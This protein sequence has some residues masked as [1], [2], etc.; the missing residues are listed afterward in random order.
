M[1][2]NLLERFLGSEHFNKDPSLTVAYLAR[3]ADHVGIQYVLC[4]KL[5]RFSYEEIE[6]FLPQLCHLLISLDNESMALE[7][8]MIDLCE[9]SVNAALLAFW[10][11][12]TYLRDLSGTPNSNAFKKCR[13]IYNRVQRIVFG[14]S[15]PVRREKIKDNVLPVTVLSSLV[16]ASVAAPFLPS[17]AGPLAI[18]QGRKPRPVE[19]MIS[20]NVQTQR[21]TRS[22]TVSGGQQRQRRARNV[23]HDPEAST[24]TAR[25]QI[26]RPNLSRRH[27]H[28]TKVQT[29]S[30]LSPRQKIRLLRSNYFKLETQFLTA[31]E[32]VS[33]RLVAVPKPARL[34]ALRAELALIAQDL[35]AEVDVPLICPATLDDGTPSKSRH[36]RI[37]RLNPAEA[38]SLNSA[39]RVPYLLM[40]EILRDDF[41]FDPESPQNNELIVKLLAE[42]NR[43]KRRLFDITDGSR[44]EIRAPVQQLENDSVFEPAMGDLA[45]PALLQDLDEDSKQLKLSSRPSPPSISAAFPRLGSGASTVPSSTLITPRNSEQQ[46]SRSSSPGVRLSS[47]LTRLQGPDQPDFNALATHMRAASQMLAQLEL[48]SSKRPKAEVASI[49]ARIIASMQTLEEQSFYTDG[50]EVSRASDLAAMMENAN[51]IG[52]QVSPEDVDVDGAGAARMENDIKTGGVQRGGD[53]DDPSAATFGEAWEVKRERI[54]RSSPYGWMKNWDL[55]SVIVKTGADLRQEAFACQLIAVCDKIWAEAGVDVWV[56]HMRILVT[57]E[58]SG[59]IETI[60]NGVSLHSLKR[61]LTLASIASGTNPRKRIAT[62]KDHFVRTFGPVDSAAHTAAADHFARS[63]AAYSVISYIL[64]LKDRHNGN[65]L[66][67]DRGHIIHIDFGFMLSNSPGSMGFEAAPFKLTAEYIEVLGG[68][69]GAAYKVFIACM[70]EAFQALRRDAERIV[71]LVELMGRE[72]RMPCYAGGVANV[73]SALRTRFVLDRSEREAEAWI[74]ELVAKSAGSYYTRLYDTFQYRTQGIY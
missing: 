49:K 54:R 5:R 68:A 1:S 10:L 63:L 28:A 4:S 36:H 74:E 53:R 66:I 14:G 46:P 26:H 30:T 37:V 61:S 34:S 44:Q 56:K 67:S 8:F 20:E 7:E 60:T 40:V 43:P 15:E 19:E 12:Q 23:A 9:E 65:I 50:D 57:G 6:F 27:S 45:S 70:K 55:V 22:H 11:F 64:Q 73:V 38:T 42:K 69:E 16:L 48:S 62:L 51:A 59:L 2:W 18:A 31:L 72:S 25:R 33:N 71:M 29:P 39:E 41:D 32:D 21:P 52:S 13:R 3:Y 58:S 17:H 35:P 47:G 24:R